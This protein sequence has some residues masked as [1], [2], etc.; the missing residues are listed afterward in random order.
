MAGSAFTPNPNDDEGLAPVYVTKDRGATWSLNANVPSERMTHD[1]T[2]ASGKD[3]KQLHT[4]I[5]KVPGDLLMNILR[6][7]DFFDSTPMTVRASRTDIDQPFVQTD[8]T[9]DR[10]Y[11]GNNDFS[12]PEQG[13]T[14]TVEVSTDG[15]MTFKAVRLEPRSTAGQDGPSIRLAIA[16]DGT[17][18]VAYFGWRSARR[19]GLRSVMV[20]SDVVVAKDSNGA[21]GPTPFQD[22]LD[23]DDGLAGVRVVTG[24]EIP[25]SNEQT[26]GSERIGSNLSLAVAPT[27]SDVVYVAW[28]DRVGDGDIYSIHVRGSTDGGKTW[29]SSDL[30]TVRDAS[31]FALA[32][33]ENGTLGFL[34]QQYTGDRWVTHLEQTTDGFETLSDTVLATVPGDQPP[35]RGMLPYLGDYNFVMAVGGEFRGIFSTGNL[36]DRANF[37]NGVQYQREVDFTSGRLLDAEGNDVDVS[38]DPFYFSAS[39]VP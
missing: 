23:P 4:A 20:K 32:V 11:V 22:L 34:Y 2:I 25:F 37:P 31:P 3:P 1:I 21:I 28:A 33:A 24:I 16:R 12:G 35:Y 8:P 13:K 7:D 36:P 39:V 5:L 26:L 17:V 18:Y 14:A 29:S 9:A 10:V 15:G 6:T 27:N 19:T 30:R 38:I